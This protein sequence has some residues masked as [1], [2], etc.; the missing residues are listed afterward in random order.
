MFTHVLRCAA[1]RRALA[2]ALVWCGVQETA[3]FVI[4]NLDKQ[5]A[6]LADLRQKYGDLTTSM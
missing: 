2:L 4:Q 5:E 6:W 1:L 3:L